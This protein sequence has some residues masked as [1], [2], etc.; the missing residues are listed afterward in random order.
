MVWTDP[1]RRTPPPEETWEEYNT[2][3]KENYRFLTFSEFDHLE[4]VCVYDFEQIVPTWA[5]FERDFIPLNFLSSYY[6]ETR[7]GKIL[8]FHL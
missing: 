8:I 5:E 3:Y 1:D 7:K 2:F 4:Y 6:M